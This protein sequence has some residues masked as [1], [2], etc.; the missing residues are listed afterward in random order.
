MNGLTVPTQK[1]IVERSGNF[2]NIHNST[3]FCL[4]TEG[5]WLSLIDTETIWCPRQALW[6]NLFVST[7]MSFFLLPGR[8]LFI[9]QCLL[10]VVKAVSHVF[11]APILPNFSFLGRGFTLSKRSLI[12]TSRWAPCDSNASIERYER[13][14]SLKNGQLVPSHP[15]AYGQQQKPPTAHRQ[16]L[17]DWS[18]LRWIGE[19]RLRFHSEHL[20]CVD[21]RLL[22]HLSYLE[23]CFLLTCRK[24]VVDRRLPF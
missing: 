4:P 13:L 23:V 10:L 8:N 7:E 2:L 19:V 1:R 20:Q 18:L 5:A 22:S 14:E 24:C 3:K 17:T 9:V 16:S 6:Q 21:E 12:Q 11:F 15:S